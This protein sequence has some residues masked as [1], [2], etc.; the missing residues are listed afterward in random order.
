MIQTEHILVVDWLRATD[1]PEWDAFVGQHPSGL[2][3]HLSSWK[4]VLEAAFPQIS[5]RFLVARDG[6]TGRIQAGMPVYTVRSWLLGNRVVSVPFATMGDPLVSSAEEFAA[7]LPE[8]QALQQQTK[9]RRVEIRARK[10][11]HLL[12]SN[13]CLLGAVGFKHL[14]ISLEKDRNSLFHTFSRTC[15]R[16]NITKAR[17]AG[18]VVEQRRD[19]TSMK[20]CYDIIVKS[21]RRLSLPQMPYAFFKAMLNFMSPQHLSLFL[22]MHKAKPVGC[23]ILMSMGQFWTAEYAGFIADAPAGVNQLLYWET[24]KSAQDQGG[25]IYSFGRT[26]AANKGLLTYKRRWAPLEEDLV[27]FTLCAR[28]DKTENVQKAHHSDSSLVYR[29]VRTLLGNVPMSFYR[30]IGD[31]W[32]RHLG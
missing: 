19:E 2:V 24:F 16:K 22:A 10:A 18:V 31:F 14:Y 28:G 27:D 29:V 15:V 17:N 30:M 6:D 25:K 32:Y 1:H 20:I 21:R 9:S 23:F 7:L 11:A 8:L 4:R 26:A 5:G 13:A 3:Y 12:P